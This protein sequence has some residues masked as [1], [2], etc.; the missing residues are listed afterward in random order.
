MPCD[1]IFTMELDGTNTSM[2]STGAGRTTCGYFYPGGQTI[3]YAS[4]HLASEACPPQPSFE[5]GYVWAIY[6]SYDIFSAAPDGSEL[7]RLTDTPGLRC[8]GDDRSRRP[9]R[10]YQCARWGYGDLLD[11]R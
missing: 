8:G 6:D 9:H 10:V 5:L 3:L 2:V 4:T 7:T 1:Q 11:E